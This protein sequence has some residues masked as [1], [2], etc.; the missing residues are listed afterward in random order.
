MTVAGSRVGTPGPGLGKNFQANCTQ[1]G[2]GMASVSVLSSALVVP[3]HVMASG[4]ATGCGET[5]QRDGDE[6]NMMA[7]ITASKQQNSTTTS[8]ARQPQA[9]RQQNMTAATRHNGPTA[10]Q[11]QGYAKVASASVPPSVPAA[12][13][14]AT[15]PGHATGRGEAPQHDGDEDNMMATVTASKQQNSTTTSRPHDSPRK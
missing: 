4:Y 6:D 14:H 1:H 15:A 3:W 10:T 5:S 11:Q 12:P 2:N 9:A 8:R 7:T 13:R